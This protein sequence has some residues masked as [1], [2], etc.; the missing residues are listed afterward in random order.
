VVRFVVAVKPGLMFTA[1][2]KYEL[3]MPYWKSENDGNESSRATC[4][5]GIVKAAS[6]SAARTA[7]RKLW[8]DTGRKI[9]FS[10]VMGCYLLEVK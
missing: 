4:S 8:K 7:F 3:L 1:H 6:E 2:M 9:R 5:G 10:G